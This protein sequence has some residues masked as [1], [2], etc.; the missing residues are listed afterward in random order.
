[1]IKLSPIITNY[2][3][4]VHWTGIDLH[5]KLQKLCIFDEIFI[6]TLNS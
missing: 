6:K 1:M 5:E 3:I 2:D 4:K